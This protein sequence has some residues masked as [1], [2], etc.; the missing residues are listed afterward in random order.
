MLLSAAAHNGARRRSAR[1]AQRRADNDLFFR[2]LEQGP[3]PPA[4]VRKLLPNGK[5][6]DLRGLQQPLTRRAMLSIERKA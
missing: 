5:L 1:D 2:S 3:N 6:V 4:S